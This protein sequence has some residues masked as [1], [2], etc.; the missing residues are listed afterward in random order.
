MRVLV[1]GGN[2]FIGKSIV[3]QLQM[4]GA[5]VLIGSRK[6]SANSNSL[7]VH[8]QS[9]L[10]IK[11]WLPLLNGVDVVVNCV[12]ILRE[13]KGGETYEKVH[14][15]AP[16]ALAQARAQLGIRMI[17]ISAIGLTMQAKS[18]FIRSKL[19]GEHAILNSG[20]DVTIVRPSLLDGEGGFGAKWFRRVATWPLQLVM[21]SEGL[22]APLQVT[23]LGEA[24]AKLC[25]NGYVNLPKVM[26]LGGNE[27][28]TIPQYLNWLRATGQRKPAAQIAVPKMMVRLASHIFDMLAW[29]PLSFGHFELM[30]GK[31][32][33][34]VN[35]LPI[36]LG[37]T[38]TATGLML[39]NSTKKWPKKT[40]NLQPNQFDPLEA[41]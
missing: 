18:R 2:G 34:A 26:E 27:T 12:G 23:D 37:R 24:V 3:T 6:K 33:P 38:P 30:Q 4:Q 36:L 35:W 11:D 32:V 41:A 19:L 5:E 28:M 17:H 15:L 9:M 22:V 40:L 16:A 7:E 20:A 14:T 8:L 13:R 25:L 31:N 10:D 21:Q 39:E 1:L 29:T